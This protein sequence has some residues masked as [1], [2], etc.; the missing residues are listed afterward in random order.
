MSKSSPH[1]AVIR[2]S[3]VAVELFQGIGLSW[4]HGGCW[5]GSCVATAQE[6]SPPALS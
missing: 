5:G 6:P 2:L 1:R 4:C 3:P